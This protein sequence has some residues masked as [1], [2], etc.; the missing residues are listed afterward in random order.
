[1]KTKV[2]NDL[3]NEFREKAARHNIE[4]DLF[5]VEV[6]TEK[7]FDLVPTS[8]R[9]Q[10]LQQM[11]VTGLNACLFSVASLSVRGGS[12]EMFYSILVVGTEEQIHT[13]ET[14]LNNVTKNLLDIFV[15]RPK[16]PDWDSLEFDIDQIDLKRVK[17]HYAFWR[18]YKEQ[19]LEHDLLFNG[20]VARFTDGLS[21]YYDQI[22]GGLDTNSTLTSNFRSRKIKVDTHQKLLLH[23]VNMIAANCFIAVKTYITMRAMEENGE[24]FPGL[25]TFRKKS[26]NSICCF[27]T[28]VH[29]MGLRIIEEPN[30]SLEETADGFPITPVENSAAASAGKDLELTRIQFL[31]R[32]IPKRY[33]FKFF[34]EKLGKELRLSSWHCAHTVQYFDKVEVEETRKLYDRRVK[35][36]LSSALDLLTTNEN[37][38]DNKELLNEDATPR[39]RVKY[40]RKKRSK[41]IICQ[42]SCTTYCSVCCVPI[43]AAKTKMHSRKSCWE[44]FHN[45]ERL[46]N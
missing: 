11:L 43:H 20:G 37:F 30:T 2:S 8:N 26:T 38:D 46:R 42:G 41:C 13:Y 36:R 9:G 6:G 23:G 17:S 14:G 21:Q 44:R 22:K 40:K 32:K 29:K 7:W 19:V 5:V 24:I 3:V 1:M 31:Q 28:W 16:S 34:T 18:S 33:R 10:V 27:S 4:S 12:V 35:K 15:E 45:C 39:A 25:R